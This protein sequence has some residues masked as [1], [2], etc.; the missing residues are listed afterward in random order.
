M[1]L[2]RR[3]V[4]AQGYVHVQPAEGHGDPWWVDY[5]GRIGIPTGDG[6]VW[7]QVDN[8]SFTRIEHLPLDG[9][10]LG[11]EEG[12]PNLGFMSKLGIV[13]VLLFSLVASACDGGPVGPGADI[14][15]GANPHPAQVG[16]CVADDPK[17]VH[18]DLQTCNN[19]H[20]DMVLCR[21]WD[22]DG[23][24]VGIETSQ[25]CMPND[26]QTCVSECPGP[27]RPQVGT[28]VSPSYAEGQTLETMPWPGDPS[29][30]TCVWHAETDLP[31]VGCEPVAGVSCVAGPIPDPCRYY[32][33]LTGAQLTRDTCWGVPGVEC[34]AVC[35]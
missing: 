34:T 2:V 20:T 30:V 5:L 21:W 7:F 29:R 10:Q 32:D 27:E 23:V 28:C 19:G 31:V 15:G 18:L 33:V 4:Q 11:I 9:A 22:A 35:S 3:L 16:N 25:G 26:H 17:A 14:V 8:Q 12:S 1:R 24:D 6:V 13:L